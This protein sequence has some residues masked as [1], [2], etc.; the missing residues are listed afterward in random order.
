MGAG[1]SSSKQDGDLKS[2]KNSPVDPTAQGPR[3]GHVYLSYHPVDT[4]DQRVEGGDGAAGRV[5]DWLT[6]RGYV[7]LLGE[8]DPDAEIAPSS[9]A[10]AGGDGTPAAA[11]R[12]RRSAAGVQSGLELSWPARMQ[13]SVEQC[14]AFVA[15]VSEH[16]GTRPEAARELHVAETLAADA[17]TILPLWHSGTWPPTQLSLEPVLA[18]L[19][20]VPRGPRPLCRTILEGVMGELLER[21]Q[22]VGCMPAPQASSAAAGGG[23]A[24]GTGG[25][26]NTSGGGL[27]A[28]GSVAA[29]ASLDWCFQPGPTDPPE[30][31]YAVVRC[32]TG[33]LQELSDRIMMTVRPTVFDLGGSTFSGDLPLL[34]LKQQHLSVAA[35]DAGN[36][37]AGGTLLVDRP[38]ITLRNGALLLRQN[39]ELR[40]LAG[41]LVLD[42]LSVITEPRQGGPRGVAL[43]SAGGGGGRVFG[44]PYESGRAMVVLAGAV[45][46]RML[47]CQLTNLGHHLALW[48]ADG[49]TVALRDCQLESPEGGGAWVRDA[50]SALVAQASRLQHCAGPCLQLEAG[51][52]AQ[53][54]GC[55]VLDSAQHNG[56]LVGSGSR[57][58]ADQCVLS[59]AQD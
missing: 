36:P 22:A 50:G 47:K 16:Y 51:G 39:Q 30:T 48:L 21:L 45:G 7:V 2:S 25:G 19:Q 49:A 33:K 9:T 8:P 24:G 41:G 57:L 55:S 54:A 46:V 18:P 29:A 4:G 13:Q 59:G 5:H 31:E 3:P 44:A 11:A 1:C 12:R 42:T 43:G 58:R 56:V 14:Q 17:T 26:D 6:S 32:Y 34:E 20:R 15:L 38:H 28:A 37:A 35:P 10:G 40:I 52:T 53:L 23:G 27:D